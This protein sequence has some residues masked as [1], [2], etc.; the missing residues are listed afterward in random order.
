MSD[1]HFLEFLAYE[2]IA[3]CRRAVLRDRLALDV[4]RSCRESAPH[5]RTSLRKRLFQVVAG[6]IGFDRRVITV[7]TS[8]R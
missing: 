7:T 2:K 1:Y 8:R 6:A 5:A 4:E 3:E